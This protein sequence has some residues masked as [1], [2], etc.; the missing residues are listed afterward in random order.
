M[1]DRARIRDYMIR[2]MVTL[3]PETE[4]LQAMNLLLEGGISGAPVIDAGGNLVG[5]LTQKD[6][7]RAALNATYFQEWGR[8]VADY[9]SR[10]V[11]TLDADVDIV[12][13]TEIFLASPYRRFPV[14]DNGRLVG[15][16]SRSDLLRALISNW[17]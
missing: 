17:Q 3:T 2:D 4:L 14:V 10:E 7:L 8:P 6:C 5:M 13:A 12:T 9:M 15:Q 16:I 1:T 11:E